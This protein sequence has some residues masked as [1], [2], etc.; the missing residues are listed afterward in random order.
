M[1]F[2]RFSPILDLVTSHDDKENAAHHTAALFADFL[3]DNIDLAHQVQNG[4]IKDRCAGLDLLKELE[5][6][7]QRWP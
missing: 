3:I 5:Q 1:I 7:A 4:F 6:R 2:K